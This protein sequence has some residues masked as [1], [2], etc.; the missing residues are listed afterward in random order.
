MN[1][2]MNEGIN[3]VG[4]LLCKEEKIKG[5]LSV[6]KWWGITQKCREEKFFKEVMLKQNLEGNEGGANYAN[7]WGKNIPGRCQNN[8]VASQQAQ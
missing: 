3:K 5:N 7:I 2:P 8:I 4:W 1:E 6:R